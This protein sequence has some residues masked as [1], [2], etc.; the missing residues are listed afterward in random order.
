MSMPICHCHWVVYISIKVSRLAIGFQTPAVHPIATLNFV[1]YIAHLPCVK[2]VRLSYFCCAIGVVR[3]KLTVDLCYRGVVQYKH[4]GRDIWV[5]QN[6]LTFGGQIIYPQM[7]GGRFVRPLN[8]MFVGGQVFF[9]F[10][11]VYQWVR[12]FM[13]LAVI[14][15]N[16]YHGLQTESELYS[17]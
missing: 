16:T 8:K 2:I 12:G 9:L 13:A 5:P 14:G 1:S 11:C 15:R 3:A 17:S 4:K 7:L 10:L 6:P